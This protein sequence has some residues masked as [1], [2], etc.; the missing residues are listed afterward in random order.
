MALDS[1]R[2][3]ESIDEEMYDSNNKET[4]INKLTTEKDEAT[5]LID[6]LCLKDCVEKL[7]KREQKIILLRY[8]RGKTQNEVAKMLGISQVQVSR[9]EKKI[10]MSMKQYLKPMI[11]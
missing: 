1:E 7:N 5:I 9:I 10:L 8:Y 6:K 11:S 3:L 4:K 2:P